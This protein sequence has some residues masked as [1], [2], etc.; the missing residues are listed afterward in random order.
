MGYFKTFGCM[1]YACM[2]K[3]LKKKFDPK[4]MKTIFM[5]YNS[6]SKAYKLWHPLKK[7]IIICRDVLFQEEDTSKHATIILNVWSFFMSLY[8]MQ[9]LMQPWN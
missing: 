9:N 8:R 7:Q 2:P 5:G 6:I 1:T 4:S 3:D